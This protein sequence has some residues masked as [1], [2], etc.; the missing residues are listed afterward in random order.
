MRMQLQRKSRK[1]TK[2]FAAGKGRTHR[3]GGGCHQA[4][5]FC[6]SSFPE[7]SLEQALSLLP[8]CIPIHTWHLSAL[9]SRQKGLINWAVF[10]ANCARVVSGMPFDLSEYPSSGNRW[11]INTICSNSHTCRCIISYQGH[12]GDLFDTKQYITGNSGSGNNW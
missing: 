8:V 2:C 11:T 10:S 1:I 4:T 12:L 9:R 7:N 6:E 5:Y 3:H